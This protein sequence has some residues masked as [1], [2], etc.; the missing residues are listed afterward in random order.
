M[1]HDHPTADT[2]HAA[3]GAPPP[4]KTARGLALLNAFAPVPRQQNRHDGWT[5]E[6][7]RGFIQALADT[8]SVKA[9]ARAVNMAPEGA[10]QLRRHPEAGQFRKAWEAALKLGVQRLEDIAMDRALHGVEVP[11]Y[12]FGQI[13]GTRRVYNDALLMFL[14]RNRATRRFSAD[15]LQRADACTQQQLKK[16][17]AQ[18]QKEWEAE[19]NR[20][21]EDVFDS[22]DRAIDQMRER[23]RAGMSDEEKRLEAELEAAYER[24]V[25]RMRQ[26]GNRGV[27]D[28]AEWEDA[29]PAEGKPA[30]EPAAEAPSPPPAP[31]EPA[32]PTGP[33]ILSCGD[34]SW[35]GW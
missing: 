5:P 7:Q 17:K 14:L 22:I 26:I 25:A 23:R 35:R 11:V 4:G 21:A 32:L 28:E 24:R 10:Y 6:R 1:K 20:E 27:D 2:A 8:G 33:R 12:H 9:A 29:A 3:D 19:Q 30:D 18:W 34:D 31:T 13:V 16:L 15:T